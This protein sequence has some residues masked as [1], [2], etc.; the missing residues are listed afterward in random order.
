MM[1]TAQQQRHQQQKPYEC[2][3]CKKEIRLQ[4]NSSNTGW[5]KFNLD[6]T[7]HVHLRKQQ[8]PKQTPPTITSSASTAQA[9]PTQASSLERKLDHL[10][11]EVQALKL[12]LQSQ[13]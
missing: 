1:T 3:T 2:F 8:Q 4:R 11:A 9:A 12:E 5:L 7:E 13:K 10:I 6:G